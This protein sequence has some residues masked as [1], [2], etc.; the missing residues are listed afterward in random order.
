[1][2]T[3]EQDNSNIHS[4]TEQTPVSTAMRE[5]QANTQVEM[6]SELQPID[7]PEAGSFKR[8]VG[9]G[10]AIAGIGIAALGVG[11]A[12]EGYTPHPK[13]N[14]KTS[15]ML[16]EANDLLRSTGGEGFLIG[17]GLFVAGWALRK[18]DPSFDANLRTTDRNRAAR[19]VGLG[20]SVLLVSAAGAGSALGDAA[21]KGASVPV[22]KIAQGLA[23]SNPNAVQFISQNDGTPN[24]N[25][26]P[27]GALPFNHSEVRTADMLA[28]RQKVLARGGQLAPYSL[29][30]GSATHLDS[31]HDPSST[32][33]ELLPNAVIQKEFGVSLPGKGMA[34]AETGK[35]PAADCVD[36]EVI[37]NKQFDVQPGE[38]ITVEGQK[39]Q[40]AKTFE[41]FPGLDRSVAIESLEQA[42]GCITTADLVT[43]AAVSGLS[44]SDLQAV[45]KEMGL[46]YAVQNYQTYKKQYEDF[47]NKSVKPPEMQLILLT[48]LTSLGGLG[49]VKLIDINNRKHTLAAQ[50]RSG[51]SRGIMIRREFWRSG[52]ES[53]KAGLFAG[54]P[55]LGFV[56]MNASSQLGIAES[57]DLKT[58]GAGFLVGLS[59]N[60]LATIAGA[61]YIKS[62]DM[63][64][65]ERS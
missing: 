17:G 49:A 10:A 1:M 21:A 2:A 38:S 27:V 7:V 28:L 63:T 15:E 50:D 45:M 34:S 22:D 56:A 18:R 43:G 55:T 41:A 31:R 44:E 19:R 37:I 36:N 5:E 59:A 35:K 42:L 47:W 46:P 14:G 39:V 62:M 16:I 12:V 13:V 11:L 32:A 52:A 6:Q 60:A 40:V 65:V 24:G 33:V 54:I 29:Y 53:V 23:P 64:K 58:L 8:F 61:A 20:L 51:T 48:M 4:A 9:K 57:Y 3:S 30:L 25:K 26:R